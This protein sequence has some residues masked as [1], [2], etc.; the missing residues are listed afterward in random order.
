MNGWSLQKKIV[1]A[2]VVCALVIAAVFAILAGITLRALERQT[3]ESARV[4]A[5]FREE[6]GK[7][8]LLEEEALTNRFHNL[9]AN[10][11]VGTIENQTQALIK[12]GIYKK[13]V[14]YFDD[15]SVAYA[16]SKE[17]AAKLGQSGFTDAAR[18][19]RA[20][21]TLDAKLESDLNKLAEEGK[22]EAR[23]V[24][25]G[26]NDELRTVRMLGQAGLADG[27]I[28]VVFDLERLVTNE[29]QF[30][31]SNET[32]RKIAM[33]QF[34][35][36]FGVLLAV[37]LFVV[38]SAFRFLFRHVIHP[39]SQLSATLRATSSHVLSV[40]RQLNE[41]SQRLSASSTESA[42][43]LEE[44]TTNLQ[45]VSTAS[46]RNSELAREASK[47][48]D[49]AERSAVEGE[50]E[51][52]LLVDAI[53]EIYEA[54]KKI[55]GISE[56]IDSIAFQTNMLALNAAIEASRAGEHGKGFAVVADAVRGLAKHSA[57]SA[58]EISATIANSIAI[59]ERGKE[60]VTRADQ[61]LTAIVTNFKRVET[62]VSEIAIA[63]SEQ[64]EGVAQVAQAVASVDA[65]T[66]ADAA[67]AEETASASAGLLEEA[68][69]LLRVTEELERI[70]EGKTGQART[71]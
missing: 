65:S 61:V 53:G 57:E 43:S 12:S 56:T 54:N 25:P 4:S 40:A 15:K 62:L 10:R 71:K 30:R 31:D 20:A 21:Q 33:R 32:T 35:I 26:A 2:V 37:G 5:A 49:E 14:F 22:S 64:T 60:R 59:A 29:K 9:L 55:E 7:I 68:H 6:M 36:A 67:M 27:W 70:V 66:Q 8:L 45:A 16:L 17:L 34:G 47:V 11:N 46:E 42:A 48:A 50:S 18:E 41:S 23:I 69:T 3:E 58:R 52:R 63:N 1:A 24:I 38:A 13:I 51:L 19:F 28:E 44:T 39:V